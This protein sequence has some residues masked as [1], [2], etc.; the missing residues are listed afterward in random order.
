[1]QWTSDGKIVYAS[2]TGENWDIWMSNADGSDAKQLTT[3]AFIDHEPSG[4]ADGRY[5]VFQSNRAGGRNIWRVDPDGSNLKQLTDGNYV[6]STPLCSADGHSV[7]FV[8]QR[9]GIATLWKVGID[10][11]APVQLTNR[12]SQLPSISPDGK[13]IAYFFADEQANN[14]PK[15]SLMS[16]EGGEP[17]KTIDLPRSVQPIAFAWLPD[18]RSV[19]Y[20]DNNSGILNVWSQPLDG[21]APKELT[22]FKSEFVNS[23]SISRDGKI[24]AYRFS[25]T[26]DIVLIKGFR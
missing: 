10:G 18:G 21:G 17:V 19:A 15:L 4:S 20:L 11:G 9:S 25:A 22:N 16:I 5:V 2:R 6:D 7:I 3:D 12:P 8:S 24:A 1:V 13:L 26:R 14:Q 23:F